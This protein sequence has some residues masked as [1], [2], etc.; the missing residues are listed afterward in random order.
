MGCVCVV[1]F[2]PWRS[3][4]RCYGI[5]RSLANRLHASV[6]VGLRGLFV[7]LGVG[8]ALLTLTVLHLPLALRRSLSGEQLAEVSRIWLLERPVSRDLGSE[9]QCFPANTNA[10]GGSELFTS[11]R[12]RSPQAASEA[13]ALLGEIPHN[14]QSSACSSMNFQHV[15]VYKGKDMS[16]RTAQA[17]FWHRS[18]RQC[19]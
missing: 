16:R 15:K 13:C 8:L 3:R 10:W 4:C 2:V 11:G 18:G 6:G 5:E 7:V 14:F 9:P 12:E 1:A 19:L 17:S